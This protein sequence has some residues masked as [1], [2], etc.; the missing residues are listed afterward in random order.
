MKKPL[1]HVRIGTVG[2]MGKSGVPQLSF[3]A[4]TK[5]LYCT[6]AADWPLKRLECVDS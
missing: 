1:L 5:L 3:K 2:H 6:C 4:L